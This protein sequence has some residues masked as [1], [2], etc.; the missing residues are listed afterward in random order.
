MLCEKAFT[1]LEGPS[2]P[3][4]PEKLVN[5][6]SACLDQMIGNGR[7]SFPAERAVGSRPDSVAHRLFQTNSNSYNPF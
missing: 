6:A 3:G 1:A 5:E 2:A 4:D 7:F